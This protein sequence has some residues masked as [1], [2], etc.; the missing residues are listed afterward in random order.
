MVAELVRSTAPLVPD[1][2]EAMELAA[3]VATA[4]AVTLLLGPA[5]AVITS[6]VCAMMLATMA[7]AFWAFTALSFSAVVAVVLVAW[8]MASKVIRSVPVV[9]PSARTTCA[10]ALASVTKGLL[11]TIAVTRVVSGV[12]TVAPAEALSTPVK[13]R[14]VEMSV[15]PMVT[16]LPWPP[17]SKKLPS[18]SVVVRASPALRMPSLLA[19]ANTTAFLM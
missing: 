18:S 2:K 19:S 14:L 5:A 11:A 10:W 6:A 8:L 1:I 3:S 7:P 12:I 4:S 17:L 15:P 9:S 13:A 16:R